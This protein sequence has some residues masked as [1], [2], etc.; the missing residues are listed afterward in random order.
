VAKERAELPFVEGN[1]YYGFCD[2][3]GGSSDSMTLAIA[4]RNNIGHAVLDLI[5][6]SKP[7][8]SP[9]KVCREFAN[10]LKDFR[11]SQVCGD[12]YA[13]EWPRER[14]SVH[15]IRYIPSEK[16][17]S[18]IYLDFLPLLNSRR[19]D[20]LDL[21]R[22]ANQ[23]AALERRASRGGRE[24]IDHAP[25]SHDDVANSA[26]GALVLAEQDRSSANP[27]FLL[28]STGPGQPLQPV[29][30]STP[31]DWKDDRFFQTPKRHF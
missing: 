16:S 29:N 4:H 25:G 28:A 21:P 27:G 5:R 20:L 13:G 15:G 9:D 11:I 3:S 10:T 30:T 31:A 6:E 8:F 22:L 1:R 12:A 17:R 18:E 7:P 23:L 2:P 14:F 19:A 24:S 26:A